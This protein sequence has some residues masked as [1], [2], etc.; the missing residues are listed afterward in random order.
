MAPALRSSNLAQATLGVR[1]HDCCMAPPPPLF[2]DVWQRKDLA[3]G[4]FGCVAAK[5]V[6]GAIFGRFAEVC[7]CVAGKGLTPF[8]FACESAGR[9]RGNMREDISSVT[10]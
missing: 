9:L 10:V 5:G 6:T 7:G 4:R 3:R 8:V 1:D 2:P